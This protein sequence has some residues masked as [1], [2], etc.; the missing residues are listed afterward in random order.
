MMLTF[1]A[2]NFVGF[3]N[4]HSFSPGDILAQ[5]P[6]N[7]TARAAQSVRFEYLFLFWV[8]KKVQTGSHLNST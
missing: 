3:P 7:A 6:V 8:V 5:S 1:F 4:S 2:V